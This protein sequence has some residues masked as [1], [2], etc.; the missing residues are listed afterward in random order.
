MLKHLFSVHLH[1][2]YIRRNSINSSCVQGLPR[3][4]LSPKKSKSRSTGSY[5]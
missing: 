1:K 3:D 4:I 5:R 2:S